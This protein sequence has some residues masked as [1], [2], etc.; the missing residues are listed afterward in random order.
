MAAVDPLQTFMIEGVPSALLILTL[1][2]CSY[3][4]DVQARVVDGRLMFDAN[5]QWGA[6]CVNEIEVRAE[7]KDEGATLWEQSASYAGCEKRFPLAY[8][9]LLKGSVFEYNTS[10]ALNER[11]RTLAIAVAPKPMRAGVVYRVLT[12]TGSTGYGCGRF[13]ISPDRK[14]Q[15]LGCS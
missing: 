1:S 2:G 3:A 13:R 8:D 12:T 5:P 4:Y 6:D 15:N 14:V 11:A 10:G 7:D 9:E